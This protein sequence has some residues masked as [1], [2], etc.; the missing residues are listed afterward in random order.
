MPRT[1]IKKYS[2][3]HLDCSVYGNLHLVLYNNLEVY[4]GESHSNS[5][6]SNISLH[7]L[8]SPNL[9]IIPQFTLLE[10]AKPS[11]IDSLIDLII[12]VAEVAVDNYIGFGHNRIGFAGRWGIVG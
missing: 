5:A 7:Y 1:R 10:N 8:V 12:G 2:S 11:S 4:L 6:P 3:P 9:L